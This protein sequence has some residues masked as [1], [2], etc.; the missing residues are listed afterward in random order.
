MRWPRAAAPRP[1]SWSATSA[2]TATGRCSTSGHTFAHALERIVAYDAARLVHGEAVAIGLCLAFRFSAHLGLCP[3]ADAA[4][5]EAHLAG[6]GLPTRL[7]QVPGGHGSVEDILDAMAQD[8][9]VK[10]GALTFIL[11]RGIGQS[12]IARGVEAEAVRGFLAQ[13]I[14]RGA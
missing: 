6:V 11:A 14:A 12:F 13:E 8:K 10:G 2:R 1:P 5:V 7:A 4:R 9:K 3:H